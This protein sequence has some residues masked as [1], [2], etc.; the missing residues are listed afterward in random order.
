ML[1]DHVVGTGSGSTIRQC[2][3]RTKQFK[4]FSNSNR[5]SLFR[6]LQS[7]IISNV[8]SDRSESL[9]PSASTE[10]SH[11]GTTQHESKAK[12]HESKAKLDRFDRRLGQIQ[13]HYS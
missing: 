10:E 1:R 8:A 7:K 3:A 12:Q 9:I 13:C 4:Q 5:S 6:V 2:S 11:D